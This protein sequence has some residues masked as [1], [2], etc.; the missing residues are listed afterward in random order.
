MPHV[1]IAFPLAKKGLVGPRWMKPPFYKRP[2]TGYNNFNLWRMRFLLTLSSLKSPQP[3]NAQPKLMPPPTPS[4]LIHSLKLRFYLQREAAG[5]PPI[6]PFGADD[7]LGWG[8]RRHD[9][10]Q[11]LKPIPFGSTFPFLLLGL[12]FSHVAENRLGQLKVAHDQF[13]LGNIKLWHLAK[14]PAVNSS[15]GHSSILYVCGQPLN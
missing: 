5:H 13:D 1:P 12:S 14:W 7:Y 11:I 6:I 9:F 4:S 8:C 3:Q 2:R 10:N 15:N